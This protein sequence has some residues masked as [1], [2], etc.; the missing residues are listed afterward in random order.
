MSR[1][2]STLALLSALFA[3]GCVS[4]H[5]A[6]RWQALFPVDGVPSGWK[7]GTWNDVSKPAVGNP[8]W[9]VEHGVLI[10][11]DP[12]DSWLMSEAEYTD[13]D[14]DFEFHLGARGNSGLALRAPAAGD[15][16][17]D[18]MELQMADVRYNPEATAAEL[19]GGLYRALAPTQQVYRPEEWNHYEVRLR[20]P[21]VW[22]RLNGVVIQ[23]VDLDTQTERVKRHDGTWAVPLKDRPRRGHIGFQDLS[24]EGTHVQIRNAR[25]RV[26]DRSTDGVY[27]GN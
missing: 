18:G 27:F 23:D 15:P 19:T 7:V 20:G 11:G 17:F 22:V 24:R 5:G 9:R 10:G 14:L 2:L 25:I 3:A 6:H 13:L 16:A 26:L 4:D 8:I 12:R 21:R 1:F